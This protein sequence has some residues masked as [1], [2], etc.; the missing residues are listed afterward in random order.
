[1]FPSFAIPL[2]L[3]AA[4]GPEGASPAVDLTASPAVAD[5]AAAVKPVLHGAATPATTRR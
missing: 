4:L 5:F 2:A 3:L 1:M